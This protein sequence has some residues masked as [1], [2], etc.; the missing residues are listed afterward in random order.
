MT[1]PIY[2]NSIA[3]I[4][5]NAK[6]FGSAAMLSALLAYFQSSAILNQI[7]PFWL[8]LVTF[9]AAAFVALLAGRQVHSQKASPERSGGHKKWSVGPLILG[10]DDD[11]LPV[12]TMCI[13]EGAD[14]PTDA[15]LRAII[16][17]GRRIHAQ[18]GKRGLKKQFLD[19][20]ARSPEVSELANRPSY[21]VVRKVIDGTHPSLSARLQERN[22]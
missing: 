17:A 13:P 16:I 4:G 3:N 20:V 18:S 21:D 9:A 5:L 15:M 14:D 1:K 10:E 2:R 12:L 6:L 11:V 8:A 22:F 7:H 19:S